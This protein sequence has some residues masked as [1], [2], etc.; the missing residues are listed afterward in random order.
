M[1]PEQGEVK[2]VCAIWIMFSYDPCQS[3]P[4]DR[5][6]LNGWMSTAHWNGHAFRSGEYMQQLGELTEEERELREEGEGEELTNFFAEFGHMVLQVESV[7]KPRMLQRDKIL[8]E[9]K[10][11]MLGRV[12]KGTESPV[13]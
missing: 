1:D 12:S 11:I 2:F 9:K 5:L 10:A 4:Q 8:L 13:V 6:K 3:K 7:C